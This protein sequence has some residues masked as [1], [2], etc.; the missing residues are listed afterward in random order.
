VIK[1]ISAHTREGIDELL[2]MLSLVAEMRELKANPKKPARG[3]VI[4]AEL[5]KGL[6]I[7]A[8][9]LVQRGTLRVGDVFLCGATYGRVRSMTSSRGEQITEAGPST[10]VLVTGWD[11]MPNAGDEFAVVADERAARTV[12]AKRA[13]LER[14]K[15][16]AK[17]HV[18]LEDF[19]A[20]MLGR[21]N[22]TLNIIIKADVQ[23]SVDV[24]ESSFSKLGNEEANVSIVHSGV[25]G[26]NESDVMLASASDAVII[27]FH[28]TAN[29]KARKLAEQEGVEIRTYRIIYEALDEVKNALAGLLAPETRE[30][31]IG[32]AEV[33]QVFRSSALGNIAGCYQLDGETERGGQARLIRNDVV[34]YD[35]RIASLRRG[36][37]DART[38]ATGFECGIKLE[39]YED[40]QTGDI[41]ESYRVESI[42]KTLA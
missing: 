1:N 19:H 21:G 26:I 42:A 24:L 39:N 28:V 29:L 31:I 17:K 36:K 40:I 5:T 38:V 22:K 4:E 10:P 11:D 14:Q 41:I 16:A 34:I 18:T 27:G 2:E 8:W 15:R 7:T 12:A 3:A 35:G 37:D 13:N 25:G 20:Q 32:H 23:G 33:R 30:V 6:G 9:I